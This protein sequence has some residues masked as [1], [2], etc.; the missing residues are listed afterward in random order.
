MT[1]TG[2]Y[3]D[4]FPGSLQP[5]YD[6]PMAGHRIVRLT[7]ETLVVVLVLLPLT[8]G[9]RFVATAAEVTTEAPEALL[10]RAYNYNL[11]HDLAI[12]AL[13]QALE[14]DPINLAAH[15]G[16][17]ALVW[18]RML[19]LGGQVLVDSQMTAT[20]R[21]SGGKQEQ[22]P[23]LDEL[24]RTHIS[25]AVELAEEAV[26]ES[27]D[28]PEA[29]Y[30]L[31]ASLA[32]VASHKA[33]VEGEGLRALRD[34]KRAYDAHQRVLELD[35]TRKDATFTLGVYRYLVSALPRAVRMMAYLVGFDGGKEE[36]LRLV[37]EAAAYP[38]DTQ[39]EAKFALVLFYNREKEFDKAQ[40]VLSELKAEYPRN[41]LVWLESAST[42]LR[43]ED[44]RMAQQD[45]AAGFAKLAAD[46]RPRMFGEDGVWLLKR[47]ATHVELRRIDNARADLEAARS[48]T[49]IGWVQG[50]ASV[51]LGKIADLEG[52]R[53]RA[54]RE[55]DR[56]RKLCDRANDRRCVSVAK[57]LKKQGYPTN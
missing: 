15:R 14:E 2:E 35:P 10:E 12:D 55:Y 24:F 31:G 51:E 30:Q 13:K 57:T 42:W 45:L 22:P 11:D 34:A 6:Q 50:R 19:F 46:E 27:P 54:R 37:E 28:D 39:A 18:L 33:T 48:E 16:M 25:R 49:A 5:R 47:G 52:D 38:G 3:P 43:D 23:D 20:I 7:A 56:G 26:K 8:P 4:Q 9:V 53:E 1:M 41:R 21:R 17:A 36:A 29:H 44:A 40:R 32:I